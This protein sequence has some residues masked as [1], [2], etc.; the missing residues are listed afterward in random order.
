M[1]RKFKIIEKVHNI[2]KTLKK[3]QCFLL[4][5]T[6]PLSHPHLPKIYYQNLLIIDI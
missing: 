5:A 6:M 4:K 1:G 3:Q 2:Q